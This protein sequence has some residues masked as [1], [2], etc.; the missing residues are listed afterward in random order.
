[1]RERLRMLSMHS[2]GENLAERAADYVLSGPNKSVALEDLVEVE[3]EVEAVRG[4][5]LLTQDLQKLYLSLT[6]IHIIQG[7]GTWKGTL[8]HM[9]K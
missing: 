6:L 1:M 8:S 9:V 4:D 5:P 3:V 7:Q 2:I